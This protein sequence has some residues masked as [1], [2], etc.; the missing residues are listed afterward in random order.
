MFRGNKFTTKNIAAY[1]GDDYKLDYLPAKEM[2][3]DLAGF[4]R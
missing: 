4:V 3:F 2:G 1:I